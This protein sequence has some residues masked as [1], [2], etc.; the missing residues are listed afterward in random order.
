[1]ADELKDYSEQLRQVN[2]KTHNEQRSTMIKLEQ[3]QEKILELE[4]Q[5]LSA[6]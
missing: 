5:L 1:M 6:K 4:N 3:A 2:G